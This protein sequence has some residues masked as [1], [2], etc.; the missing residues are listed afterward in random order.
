MDIERIHSDDVI[1]FHFVIELT[2]ILFLRVLKFPV[3]EPVIEMENQLF[4]PRDEK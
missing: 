2:A 1:I 4:S 3:F